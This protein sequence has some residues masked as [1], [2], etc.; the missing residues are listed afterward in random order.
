M[1]YSTSKIKFKTQVNVIPRVVPAL[2][3]ALEVLTGLGN[4]GYEYPLQL[5]GRGTE[6]AETREYIAG[7]DIRFINWKATARL[8]KL[9]VNQFY[10]ETEGTTHLVYDT[11]VLGDI[12]NDE[13]ATE[14]LNIATALFSSGVPYSISIVDELGRIYTKEHEDPRSSLLTAMHYVLKTT[15]VNFSHLY[16][17]LSPKSKREAFELLNLISKE[18]YEI[19]DKFSLEKNSDVIVVSCLLGDLSW[20]IELYED[21]KRKEGRLRIVSC[22]TWLDSKDLESAYIDYQRHSHIVASLMKKGIE[23]RLSS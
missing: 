3:R 8:Q 15:K 14:F 19:K 13:V 7:D 16:Y 17:F 5:I 6:Y 18:D 23:V 20:L 11:K 10:Q 21:L 22:K 9:M 1:A 4:I 2:I 12:S